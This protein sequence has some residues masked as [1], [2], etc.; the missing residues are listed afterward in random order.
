MKIKTINSITKIV[1]ISPN[2]KIL[3]Y[4]FFS[5]IFFS[6]LSLLIT[7]LFADRPG[8]ES[9][10]FSLSDLQFNKI[11]ANSFSIFFK[12]YYLDLLFLIATA[13]LL[14][15]ISKNINSPA[16][17]E[18]IETSKTKI[19]KIKVIFCTIVVSMNLIVAALINSVSS[20]NYFSFNEHP[21]GGVLLPAQLFLIFT[22]FSCVGSIP[23]KNWQLRN[24]V[25]LLLFISSTKFLFL[26]FT[27][28]NLNAEKSFM[29]GHF[30]SRGELSKNYPISTGLML[31]AIPMPLRPLPT[32]SSPAWFINS[33]QIIFQKYYG[34]KTTPTFM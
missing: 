27:N 7:F 33:Y 23:N 6:S 24:F 2:K 10:P 30:Y 32:P 19:V 11:F 15:W 34:I 25:I 14:F 29:I 3:I 13:L 18:V 8:A 28:S 16:D 31:D 12:K 20:I 17:E 1:F 22:I 9:H 21:W 5:I 4:Y 26:F